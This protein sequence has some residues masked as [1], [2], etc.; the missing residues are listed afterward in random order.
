MFNLRITI[1]T[2]K[3]KTMA[4][5]T[6]AKNGTIKT[7]I[8]DAE[9][10]EIKCRFNNDDCVEMDTEYLKY[11]TLSKANL[12]DLINSIDKA[13]ELYKERKK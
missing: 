2:F 10:D 3:S 11:I 8:F 1:I 7:K 4:K 6:T 9:S 13:E 5:L 12:F